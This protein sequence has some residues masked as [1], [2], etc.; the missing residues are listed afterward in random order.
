MYGV[1]LKPLAGWERPGEIPTGSDQ[2]AI[3]H[4]Q[5]VLARHTR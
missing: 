4:V 3:C 2:G 5:E 1:H